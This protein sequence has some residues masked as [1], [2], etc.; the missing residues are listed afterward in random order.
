MESDMTEQLTH[1]ICN[2]LQVTNAVFQD[3]IAQF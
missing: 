2:D 1:S 3:I